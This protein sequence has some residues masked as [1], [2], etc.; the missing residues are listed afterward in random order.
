[1]DFSEV[2]SQKKLLKIK[3]DNL[4]SLEKLEAHFKA[5]E[6]LRIASYFTGRIKNSKEDQ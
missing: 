3:P 1:M 2:E 5:Q 6:N 4:E